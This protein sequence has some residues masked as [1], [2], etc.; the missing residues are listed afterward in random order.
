MI[1]DKKPDPSELLPDRVASPA[2]ATSW[3]GWTTL[4]EGH[5]LLRVHGSSFHQDAL[6][7]LG[8]G[9]RPAEPKHP[10][11]M[12]TLRVETN[13]EYAGAV[14][15]FV[16][17]REVGSIPKNAAE[18]Y[19]AVV[20]EVEVTTG[21]A[22]CRGRVIGGGLSY[23]GDFW[24]SFGFELL[25]PTKPRARAA[26]DPFLPP[27]G[28]FEVLLDEGQE[29]HLDD[30]LRSKAKS[31]NLDVHVRL[32]VGPPACRV[33]LAGVEVGGLVC[34]TGEL[35]PIEEAVAAGFPSTAWA[36]IARKPGRPT[37][38]TVEAPRAY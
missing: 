28:F 31:K 38:L 8:G 36:R 32:R 7:M 37:T 2:P 13:G 15:V 19:S 3:L 27:T 22:T 25:Q 1:F 34:E 33:E 20:E 30:M 11:V 12:A 10:L 18:T 16:G 26:D 9:A 29:R 5:M 6:Q 4:A 24:L 21:P 23:E 14:R 35:A 17:D